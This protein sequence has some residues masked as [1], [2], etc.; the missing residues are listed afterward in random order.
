MK[1][2][3]DLK[4][5]LSQLHPSQMSESELDAACAM[6]MGLIVRLN[7]LLDR[8]EI[9]AGASWQAFSPTRDMADYGMVVART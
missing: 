4:Q 2:D 1:Q 8:A 5:H 3:Y 6:R 9:R 7:T